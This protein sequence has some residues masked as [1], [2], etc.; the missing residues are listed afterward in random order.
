MAQNTDSHKA[1]YMTLASEH[2]RQ[3]F[4]PIV[5]FSLADIFTNP[6]SGSFSV[7]YDP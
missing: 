7:W 4:T 1:S 5:I 6:N 2:C 3:R